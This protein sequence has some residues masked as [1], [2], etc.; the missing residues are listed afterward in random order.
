MKNTLVFSIQ[1][2]EFGLDLAHVECVIL[3]TEVNPLLHTSSVLGMINMHG[4]IVPV[5]NLRKIFD[6][7]EREIEP[8]DQFIICQIASETVAFWID[9]VQEIVTNVKETIT[10]SHN[11]FSHLPGIEGVI[12]K[13]PQ[14]IV[15]FNPEKIVSAL[16]L[17][18]TSEQGL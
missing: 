13:G 5:I 12:K 16:E 1:N 11:N 3:A 17:N 7:G 18:K 9:R 14:L 8:D 15:I 4:K 6:L 10:L 2:N